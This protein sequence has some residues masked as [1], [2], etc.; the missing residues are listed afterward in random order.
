MLKTLTMCTLMTVALTACGFQLR[1]VQPD[2]GSQ[3]KNITQNNQF[4]Q[5][6]YPYLKLDLPSSAQALQQPLELQLAR[7]GSKVV[8][9]DKVA[10]ELSHDKAL[11]FHTLVVHD[12][13]LQRLPLRGRLTEVQLRMSLSFVL[14]DNQGQT[15]T[16]PRTLVTQRSYQYDTATINTEN[17]EESYLLQQMYDDLATQLAAQLYYQ[18]LPAAS[19]QMQD[20]AQ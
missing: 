14:Q 16:A 3:V 13:Q 15:I 2:L 5:V 7:I 20:Q 11:T 1:G 6:A 10:D 19:T 17:Q 4:N 8:N 12:Y 9:D 18:R